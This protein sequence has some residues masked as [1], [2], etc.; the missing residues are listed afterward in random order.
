M[1]YVSSILKKSGYKVT[2]ALSSGCDS[3]AIA[4]FIKTKYPKTELK[5][6]H[7]NHKLRSQNEVMMESCKTFCNDFDINLTIKE[8]LV[9]SERGVSE[10]DMREY[11]YGAMSGL[12]Y[13]L[14]GHHL[15]DAVENYLNNCFTGN[16]EYLPISPVTKWSDSLTILR[17]FILNTKHDIINYINSNNLLKYVVEDETNKQNCYRRNWLR[18]SI[19]PQINNNGYNLHTIVRKRYNEF[20]QK[21][22]D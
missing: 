4:H 2:V 15:D 20:F 7:Y 22:G 3:I 5:C 19:V 11:R 9:D 18:N 6:F 21:K 12:G 13:V 17:P 1:Q 16:P 10:C 8:R 14:T